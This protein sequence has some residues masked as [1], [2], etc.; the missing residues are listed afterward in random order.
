MRTLPRFLLAVPAVAFVAACSGAPGRG[1][2]ELPNDLQKDLELAKASSLELASSARNRTQVVSGLEGGPAGNTLEG[3]R[4]AQPV[5]APRHTPA[6]APVK[7]RGAQTVKAPIAAP[8]A[9]AP[10]PTTQVAESPAATESETPAPAAAP[11]P[12]EPVVLTGPT[13][14]ADGAGTSRPR[15][16]GGWGGAGDGDVYGGRGTGGGGVIIRGGGIGDDDHCEIRPRGYPAGGRSYPFPGTIYVPRP[17]GTGG[18][19]SG[20]AGT[21]RSRGGSPTIR[22]RTGGSSGGAVRAPSSGRTRSRG[23]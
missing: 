18:Y 6:P 20:S 17:G 8:A 15:D 21:P 10:A 7:A 22:Q 14:T 5:A 11:A 4:V 1:T 12:A 19:P 9:E 23:S 3:D 2:A 16:P 13:A